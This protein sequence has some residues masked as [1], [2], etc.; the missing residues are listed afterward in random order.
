V[1]KEKYFAA[2]NPCTRVHLS[3]ATFRAI[4]EEPPYT[5]CSCECFILTAAV[6]HDDFNP[7]LS[8]RRKTF[9]GMRQ[10]LGL[11]EYRNYDR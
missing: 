10:L 2:S 1:Q 6:H 5:R 8:H 11:I 7:T 9:Q 4:H 3:R